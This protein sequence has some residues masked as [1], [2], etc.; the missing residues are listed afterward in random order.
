MR[1]VMKKLKL[2]T[3]KKHFFCANILKQR[4]CDKYKGLE[5]Q[6]R[7][8]SAVAGFNHAMT[9]TKPSAKGLDARQDEYEKGICSPGSL[10]NNPVR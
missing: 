6:R 1:N 2:Q 4:L 8:G 3:R 5:W 9:K 10:V 7:I